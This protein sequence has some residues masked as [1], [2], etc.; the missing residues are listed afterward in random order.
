MS[1]ILPTFNRAEL[2]EKALA[3]IAATHF[4]D[5][6]QVEVIVVDNNSPDDI[7]SIVKGLAES[8]PYQLRYVKE[9]TQGSSRARNRGVNEANGHY[10]VFMDDDQLMD[11]HYLE[12]VPRAFEETG[13]NCVGGPVTYYNAENLPAWLRE[14]SRTIGQ[15]SFGEHVKVLGPGT[16]KGLFGGNIAISKSEF[17]AA[18]GFNVNLGHTGD[19]MIGLEDFEFQDRVRGLGKTVAYSPHLIQYH[20]LRPERF[21]KNYWREYY[22]SYG[23]SAYIRK[24]D[25]TGQSRRS[26]FR[27]PVWLWRRLI[28]HDVPAYC[29]SFLAFDSFK[30]FRKELE[31]WARMGQIREARRAIKGE[32]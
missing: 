10:V 8:F 9:V 1:V 19:D 20:Y 5:P 13:A 28:V 12:N 26:R 17:I 3:S 31:I 14:L 7:A 22:Y 25:E 4:S 15:I 24:S 29:A 30:R 23:R 27:I 16:H 32:K 18:G 21:K 2:L 11:S 6:A